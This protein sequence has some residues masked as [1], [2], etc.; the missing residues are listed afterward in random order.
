MSTGAFPLA[1]IV[2]V[3]R[4]GV[5]GAENALP[6][7]LP[8]DLR[9]FK[10][11]TLGKPVLMGRRTWESIGRPLPGRHVIVVTRSPIAPAGVA[12]AASIEAA[13]EGAAVAART[14]A[15]TEIMVAGGGTIYRALIGQA[16]RLYVT[17]VEA[18]PAGDTAF[19]PIDLATWRIT[20]RVVPPSDAAD[21]ARM[22]FLTYTRL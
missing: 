4:N 3:G 10:A 11:L 16:E 21:T 12:A 6:W 17:A 8:T 13:L 22:T 2:A 7:R 18:E 20:D 19:P 9:H 14:M 15:A 5:I 1:L